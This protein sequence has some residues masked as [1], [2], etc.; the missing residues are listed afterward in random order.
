[1]SGFLNFIQVCSYTWNA[2]WTRCFLKLCKFF[3]IKVFKIEISLGSENGSRPQSFPHVQVMD[4]WMKSRV[5]SFE[6][7]SV[8][9]FLYLLMIFLQRM[10]WEH[11]RTTIS[12]KTVKFLNRKMAKA[13]CMGW[14]QGTQDS[15]NKNYLIVLI[16]KV[17]MIA[18]QAKP[19]ICW[20][21]GQR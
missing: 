20:I 7:A 4:N 13:I 11:H 3:T 12:R 8:T 10:Y 5:Y 19:L 9:Y 17:F 2:I 18:I 15:R 1:M 6:E 14:C 21:S 16:S